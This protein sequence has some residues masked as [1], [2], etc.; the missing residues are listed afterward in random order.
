MY[1][2]FDWKHYAVLSVVTA[3]SSYAIGYLTAKWEES[4]KEARDAGAVA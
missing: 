1:Y 2:I 4:Y 3:L